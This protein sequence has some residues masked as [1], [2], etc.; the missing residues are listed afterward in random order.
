MLNLIITIAFCW[1]Y[2]L[3][4]QNSGNIAEKGVCFIRAAPSFEFAGLEVGSQGSVDVN[5]SSCASQHL[6]FQRVL[7]GRPVHSSSH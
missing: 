4:F 6:L 7:H 5:L 3:W 2:R 1:F